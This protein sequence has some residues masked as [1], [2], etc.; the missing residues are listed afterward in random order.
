MFIKETNYGSS[1]LA[2]DVFEKGIEDQ[3]DKLITKIQ[4]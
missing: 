2:K 4:I 3:F 1:K